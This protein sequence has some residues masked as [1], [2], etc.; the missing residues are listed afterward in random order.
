MQYPGR[1]PVLHI[2]IQAIPQAWTQRQS[3]PACDD[4]QTP[5][6]WCVLCQD[7][8]SAFLQVRTTDRIELEKIAGPKACRERLRGQTKVIQKAA[9]VIQRG[10]I[11]EE[12][13][14]GAVALDSFRQW[15]LL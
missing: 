12:R 10:L 11:V 15:A 3:P 7:D 14:E 13:A 9:L 4:G 2:L 8:R 6:V 1:G 5:G